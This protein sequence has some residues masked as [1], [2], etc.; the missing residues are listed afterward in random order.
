MGEVKR[1]KISK[2]KNR[3]ILLNI[4]KLISK[5]SEILFEMCEV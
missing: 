3:H 4:L 1:I 2:E 5:S